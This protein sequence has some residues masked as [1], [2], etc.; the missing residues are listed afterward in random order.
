[1]TFL[2]FL[3]GLF[4]MNAMPHYVLGTW[5]QRMLSAFGYSDMGN[6]VYGLLNCGLSLGLFIWAH[7]VEAL[8]EN[9][10]YIGALTVLVCFFVLGTLWRKL[11]TEQSIRLGKSSEAQ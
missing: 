11:F 2:D 1:M 7:G 4:L 6:V 10:I 9:G 8:F 5:R 3:I